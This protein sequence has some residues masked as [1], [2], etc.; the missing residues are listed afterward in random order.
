MI[1][2][3]FLKD[4]RE[5][6]GLK[7][8]DLANL[9]FISE[10]TISGYETNRR[11]CTFNFG[12]EILN[13]LNVAVLIKNNTITLVEGDIDMTKEYTN[14][15]L[16]FINFNK[17]SYIQNVLNH[18]DNIFSM[19]HKEFVKAYDKNIELGFD[20][21]FSPSFSEKYWLDEH[22]ESGFKIASF[23]KDSKEISLIV[24]G[25]LEINMFIIER[26]I[27]ILAKT[28]ASVA[29][30][31]YKAIL[32]TN[33]SQNNGREI[34]EA[35]HK[36]DMIAIMNLIP[37]AANYERLIKD[38]LLNHFDYIFVNIENGYNPS[39]ISI[40]NELEMYECSSTPNLYFTYTMDDGAEVI[41]YEAYFE[42]HDISNAF[43][44]VNE[45]FEDYDDYK[46]E[47]ELIDSE[48]EDSSRELVII[49]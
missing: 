19:T 29:E 15:N 10:K 23:T 17:D 11:Q 5:L 30:F 38:T 43:N 12:M 9:L 2:E 21:C 26:F 13:K 8:S 32:F 3:Q 18:R 31:I 34:Y 27:E 39:E 48:N 36:K 42:G 1:F 47:Y 6:I 37:M 16:D 28:D 49:N 35:F 4:L 44:Y 22:Y 20:T 25:Y 41:D 24:E 7:Q 33:A 14:T 40:A 45:Y 46:K